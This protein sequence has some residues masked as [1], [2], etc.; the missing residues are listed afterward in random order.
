MIYTRGHRSDF[1]TWAADGNPGW[2]YDEVLPFYKYSERCR[3]RYQDEGYHG[4]DGLLNVEEARY[5]TPLRKTFIEAGR[6][7]GKLIVKIN[8]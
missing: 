6:E 7:R 5:G 2:T 3:L 1:D 8:N 4:T